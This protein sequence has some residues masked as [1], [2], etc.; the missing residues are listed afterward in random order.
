MTIEEFLR[1]FSNKYA[2]QNVDELNGTVVLQLKKDVYLV[3][4]DDVVE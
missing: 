1:D 2:V 4:T 3:R